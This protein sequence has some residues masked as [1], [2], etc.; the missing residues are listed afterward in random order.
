LLCFS[1]RDFECH[2]V[3]F[4]CL[5]SFLLLQGFSQLVINNCNF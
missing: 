5:L 4:C 3:D 2:Q 1:A